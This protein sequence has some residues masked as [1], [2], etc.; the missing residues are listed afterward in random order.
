MLSVTHAK[1][2]ELSTGMVITSITWS[3]R[4]VRSVSVFLLPYFTV[5]TC[6][7]DDDV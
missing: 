3:A 2:A 1:L 6:V 7:G 4:T 5:I